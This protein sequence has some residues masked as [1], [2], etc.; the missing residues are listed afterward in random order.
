MLLVPYVASSCRLMLPTAAR[1]LSLFFT[2][3]LLRFT[4]LD[5]CHAFLSCCVPT[6]KS[7]LHV[8]VYRVWRPEDD[9]TCK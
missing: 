1:D 8:G 4:W 3:Q 5:V 9:A 2:F 6:D 7:F